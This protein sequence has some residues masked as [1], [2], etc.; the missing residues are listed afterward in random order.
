MRSHLKFSA[1]LALMLLAFS[2]VGGTGV[3][4]QDDADVEFKPGDLEGIEHAVA[5]SYT[6]DYEAM[7]AMS[8]PGAEPSMPSGVLFIGG[9]VLEFDDNGN[10]EG[11]FDKLLEE[12][13][14]NELTLSEEGSVEEYDV[15]LGNKSAGFFSLEETEGVESQT[16]IAI[17]QEDSFIYVISAAGSDVDMKDTAKSFIETMMGNDGSGEG[18]FNEDGTS[19]GGLWDKFSGLDEEIVTDLV[20]MDEI[21]FPE[22]ADDDA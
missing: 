13:D 2:L 17:V 19:T 12:L 15:D 8:T 11:G 22:P 5:R 21:I 16:T 4:A 1:L 6:V 18:E 7:F 14:V 3:G 20:A 10:A 9:M